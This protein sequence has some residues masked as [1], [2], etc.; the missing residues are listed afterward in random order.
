MIQST[1]SFAWTGVHLKTHCIRR[2]RRRHAALHGKYKQHHNHPSCS[3][4]DDWQIFIGI[5]FPILATAG[6][7]PLRIEPDISTKA[8]PSKSQAYRGQ[9]TKT[10]VAVISNNDPEDN[11]V[12]TNHRYHVT[13]TPSKSITQGPLLAHAYRPQETGGQV[14]KSSAAVTSI[15]NEDGVLVDYY[16]QYKGN[17]STDDGWPEKSSWISFQDLYVRTIFHS[18]DRFATN[19]LRVVPY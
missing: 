15:D 12:H 14:N 19:H 1:C 2:C 5:F 8:S 13:S 18:T 4:T 3:E 17:G 9:V 10:G 6:L 11:H 16:N 7:L